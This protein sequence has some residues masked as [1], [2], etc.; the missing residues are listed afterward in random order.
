MVVQYETAYIRKEVY[1]KLAL[2]KASLEDTYK[3][4]FTWS[5]F[6]DLLIHSGACERVLAQDIDGYEYTL[7]E[8][9]ELR[10]MR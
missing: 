2:K 3:R 5:H 8:S 6:F 7:E 9:R 4:K 10:V 1:D